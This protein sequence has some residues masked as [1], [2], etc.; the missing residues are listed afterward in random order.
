MTQAS[1]FSALVRGLYALDGIDAE[2]IGD[3]CERI[4]HKPRAAEWAE[5]GALAT[6]PANEVARLERTLDLLDAEEVEV[7]ER[8]QDNWSDD[9][10]VSL[11]FGLLQSVR[12]D[13]KAVEEELSQLLA[14]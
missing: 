2:F 14:A 8:A 12:E 5:T 11:C 4:P 13:M 9:N 1:M 7:R 3:L 6:I 10:W